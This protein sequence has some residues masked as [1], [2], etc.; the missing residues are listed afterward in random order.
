MTHNTT[1]YRGAMQSEF[2]QHSKR[3]QTK[4]RSEQ[5]RADN[6]QKQ[7]HFSAKNVHSCLFISWESQG[8]PLDLLY[9]FVIMQVF[10]SSFIIY[11][12]R[13]SLV[14]VTPS[15]FLQSRASL[16]CE[17]RQL[18]AAKYASIHSC[19]HFARLSLRRGSPCLVLSAAR[20]LPTPVH[21]KCRAKRDISSC[22][23]FYA[24]AALWDAKELA[25]LTGITTNPDKT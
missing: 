5:W 17:G 13:F 4:R 7:K 6:S 12:D 10:W 18:L 24:P 25:L 19:S 16:I 22:L 2:R 9:R 21:T 23:S 8:V 3:A 1:S 14:S 20:W 11:A 15:S